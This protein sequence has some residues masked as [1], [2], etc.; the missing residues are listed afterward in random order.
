FPAYNE[1]KNITN[2]VNQAIK[3]IRK[4]KIKEYEIIVVDDGSTDNTAKTVKQL[5]KENQKI[6]LIQ[7]QKNRGYGGALKTGFEKAQFDWIA[8]TDSDGQFDFQEFEKFITHSNK[9]S[10]V[11]GYRKKRHDSKFR[12]LLAKMLHIWDLVLFGLNLK[13]VDCGFKLIKK[14][15]IDQVFPLV[16]ESAITETE[17]M[18]KIHRTGHPIKQVGV[19]HHSRADGEQTGGKFKVIF[20]AVIESLKLFWHFN[21]DN[22][23]LWLV[24][25]LASFLRLYKIEPYLNF[26][27]DEGRDAL[28]WHHMLQGDFTLLG[29]TA[30]VGGFYLGPIYYYLALPFYFLFRSPVGPAIFVALLGIT[31]VYLVYWLVKHITYSK[32]SAYLSA[33]IY[34]VSPLV[35]R[36]SRFSWNPNPIPFFTLLMI[37]ALYQSKKHQLWWLVAGACLGV[38]WQLHYLALG[39]ALIIP[40]YAITQGF[41]RSLFK[42]LLLAFLGWL[43]TF[44]PF[45]LFELR[46]G[47]PNFQTIFE[48]ITRKHGALSISDGRLF[49]K[50]LHV[51]NQIIKPL[52]ALQSEIGNLITIILSSSLIVALFKNA[53]KYFLIALWWV[54]FMLIFYLYRGQ[55]YPYYFAFAFPLPVILIAILISQVSFTRFFRFAIVIIFIT[56]GSWL[57]TKNYFF[58][59][60]PS[61]LLLQTQNVSQAVIDLADNQPFNFALI[62][63]GN[64]D[65]AYRYFLEKTNHSNTPLENM[66]T[67]QLIVVCEQD[68]CK[69]LGHPIWEIAAFGRAEIISQIMPYPFITVMKLV[70]HSD[71]IDLVGRPAPKLY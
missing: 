7:H 51:N 58:L 21:R 10:V 65:H 68:E 69:P 53:R 44:S 59:H 66:V 20:K 63:P 40:L 11:V 32:Y 71:S 8:F 2:T 57:I 33:L 12:H 28:V 37:I 3:V 31:S 25:A 16:T 62:T 46:H 17:L 5:I 35:V 9:Y 52:F 14:S 50:L 15:V 45:L 55:I 34:A 36:Y 4:L 54:V 41:S 29:P 1:A 42:N 27:G 23:P 13:D 43:I 67:E 22:W 64:S 49:P 30:S 48:F 61:N 47:F 56:I 70:H 6:K 39:L 38:L 18:V 19:T 60:P 26:L 24:L